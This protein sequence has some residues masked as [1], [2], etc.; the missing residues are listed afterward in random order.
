M[1]QTLCLYVEEGEERD[2][3][4]VAS[5]IFMNRNG[6]IPNVLMEGSGPL[7]VKERLTLILC[8]LRL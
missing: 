1:D 3:I 5:K 2:K 4:V 7:P 6:K 8:G